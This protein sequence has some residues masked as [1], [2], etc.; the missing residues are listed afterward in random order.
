MP[1]T[2]TPSDCVDGRISELVEVSGD[3][4]S[5][6][7]LGPSPEVQKRGC[8]TPQDSSMTESQLEIAT[9]LSEKRIDEASVSDAELITTRQMA[10]VK[11]ES[12]IK[13]DESG[14]MSVIPAES[15][16]SDLLAGIRVDACLV[17][18]ILCLILFVKRFCRM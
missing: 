10:K 11:Q 12:T 4:V 18:L 9:L 8:G 15:S 16:A 7:G 3:V 17:L 13:I 6:S 1:T 14:M 2:N 5:L